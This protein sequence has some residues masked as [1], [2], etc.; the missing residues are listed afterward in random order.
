MNNALC[1]FTS[2]LVFTSI[3]MKTK[4]INMIKYITPI[5]F[6]TSS[7][8]ASPITSHSAS[9]VLIPDK[10]QLSCALTIDI[11]GYESVDSQG[12]ENNRILDISVADRDFA[13][14]F[15]LSWDLNLS[16]VGYSWASDS[17]IGFSSQLFLTPGF[18]D[19]FTVTNANYS[20]NGVINL[21][22][23]G[24]PDI[25]LGVDSILSLEFF[26][27]YDDAP[28]K[29]DAIWLP[30]STITIYSTGWLPTPSAATTIALAT[31]I[32][33]RRKR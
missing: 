19:N 2:T 23:I 13:T 4:M 31:L 7:V 27:D 5:S 14:I 8:I 17:R 3:H 29:T 25:Q 22:N 32:T 26:E 9:S 33:S 11:S 20:S 6:I 30:G 18:D 15:A 12:S 21:D 28:G 10:N 1:D 24:L 16:T